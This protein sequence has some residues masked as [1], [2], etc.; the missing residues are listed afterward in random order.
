VVAVTETWL[1]QLNEDI[2]PMDGYNFIS[3]CR[4]NKSHR[5]FGFY[6]DNKHKC[7][8]RDDLFICNNIIECLFVEI[9][10]V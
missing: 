1:N 3:N 10:S 5:G 8:I 6:I 9:P 2:F 4:Q 7:N